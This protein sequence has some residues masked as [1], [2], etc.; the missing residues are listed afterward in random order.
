LAAAESW[1]QHP[2]P[3][4]SRDLVDRLLTDSPWAKPVTLP[5]HFQPPPERSRSDSNDAGIPASVGLLAGIRGIGS[6]GSQRS[7]REPR[8][9]GQDQTPD[10]NPRVRTEVCLTIRWSSALPI[11]QALALERWMRE[12][13]EHP[14]AIEFL[15]CEEPDYVVEILGFPVQLVPQGTRRLEAELLQTAGVLLKGHGPIQATSAYVPQH[16][17]HLSA[18]LRFPRRD[19][20]RADDGTLEFA[21]QAWPMKIQQKFKLKAMIYRGR[22]EL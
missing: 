20:I 18:E 4:W 22:L 6:P 15:D 21:A 10:G 16:G 2:F 14:K 13:L 9:A 1:D 7:G 11:R 8:T 3:N 17:E 5:F 12:G 19:P